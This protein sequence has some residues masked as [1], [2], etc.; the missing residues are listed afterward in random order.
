MGS[1]EDLTFSIEPSWFQTI[2]IQYA[3][4]WLPLKTEKHQNM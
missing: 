3:R 1:K 2:S 4:N